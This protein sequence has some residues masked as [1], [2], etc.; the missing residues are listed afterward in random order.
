M[1]A[2][3]WEA[4]R[5]DYRIMMMSGF[6]QLQTF[7]EIAYL[8]FVELKFYKKEKEMF[9]DITTKVTPKIA[10]DAQR[11]E[12]KAL[13]GHIGTHFDVMNKEFPLNYVE[14]DGVRFV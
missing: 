1:I 4:L 9:I 7:C 3:G 6:G 8:S 2:R 11:N 14:R 5:K 12:K 13:V 10:L